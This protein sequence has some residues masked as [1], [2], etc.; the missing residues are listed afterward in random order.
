MCISTLYRDHASLLVILILAVNR[1]YP[2]NFYQ[3]HKEDL[4][5]SF[6]YPKA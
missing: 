1:N 3:K 6:I 4:G 5:F 2:M